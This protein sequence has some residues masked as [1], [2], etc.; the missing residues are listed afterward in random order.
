MCEG[1]MLQGPLMSTDETLDSALARFE[2]AI[3][4]GQASSG[5]EAAKI[6]SAARVGAGRAHLQQ[7]NFDAA[8][9]A[10]AGV[11]ADFVHLAVRVDDAGNRGRAGNAVYAGT[12]GRTF[13]V[14][15]A[16]RTLGDPRVPSAATGAKA[17]DGQLDLVVQGKYTDYGADMRISSG[18]EARYI[19][20]EAR[21]QLG[22]ASAALE[23][24]AER[25]AA[26]EQDAFT[27]TAAAAVLAEL[28]DQ[29]ARDFWLEGKAMGDFRRNPTAAP[30]VPAPGAPFYKPTQGEFGDL[31]CVPIPKEELDTN[32]NI[33]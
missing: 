26:G 31:T 25:R 27:G 4:A 22:D 15:E 30:Y 21:L 8:I 2:R 19:E 29:R 16:Y 11:A 33:S 28:M 1:V 10:V 3:A 24:I 14:P 17:Q 32:P 9:Q 12:A 13:V 20:A 18:L 7:G 23:L 6:V 5:A